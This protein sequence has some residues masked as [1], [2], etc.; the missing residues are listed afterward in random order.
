MLT[1]QKSAIVDIADF[2]RFMGQSGTVVMI[3]VTGVL[4]TM[5]LLP[6][7]GKVIARKGFWS[8]SHTPEKV[9]HSL[10]WSSMA[11]SMLCTYVF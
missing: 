2:V 11:M 10:A 7:V 8:E 9:Q 6:T 3:N 5:G 4:M 1:Q